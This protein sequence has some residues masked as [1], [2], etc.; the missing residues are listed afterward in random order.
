LAL[1]PGHVEAL[2]LLAR[3]SAL[4]QDEEAYEQALS[5]LEQTETGRPWALDMKASALFEQAD[6]A[7]DETKRLEALQM[8]EQVRDLLPTSPAPY[9]YRGL[10]F[11][12]KG[13]FL[14][15]IIE[16]D[17]ALERYPR[18]PIALRWKAEAQ[19]AA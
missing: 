12:G 4:V 18:H 14:D 3:C 5:G 10:Y 16:L 9:I 6:A 19:T 15:A 8:F 1:Q 17:R 7:N 13:R 11:I 2:F